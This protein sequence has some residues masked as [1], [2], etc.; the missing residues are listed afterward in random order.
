MPSKSSGAKKKKS[1]SDERKKPKKSGKQSASES[2]QKR[3]SSSPPGP[4]MGLD[5]SMGGCGVSVIKGDK[6]LVLDRLKTAPEGTNG[7][8]GLLASG[9][10]LGSD[11]ERISFIVKRIRKYW[12]EHKVCFVVIEGHA[13]GI[14]KSRSLTILHELHG[15][16]KH[17]VLKDDLAFVTESPTRIKLFATMDGKAAKQDMIDAAN[18]TG[19]VEV[20]DSDRADA[21]WLGRYGW[22][23]FDTLTES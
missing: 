13:F 16:V 15:V 10:F 4:V 3:K 19:L 14:V 6:V 9:T 2:S 21:F 18:K 20:H 17:Y 12:R 8:R 23:N 11:E 5:L 1:D 22:E 7:K